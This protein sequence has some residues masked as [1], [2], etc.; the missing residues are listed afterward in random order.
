M[1]KGKILLICAIIAVVILLLV[2][3]QDDTLEQ[4]QAG[5]IT[6]QCHMKDGVRTI[7]PNQIEG[8]TNGIWLFAD[9]GYAKSCEII[10]GGGL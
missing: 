7:K 1:N 2:I 5:V 9:N 3:A 6:L 10:K 8:I 4:A